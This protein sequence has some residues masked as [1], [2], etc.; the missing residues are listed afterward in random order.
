MTNLIKTT[1]QATDVTSNE[2]AIVDVNT[3]ASRYVRFGWAIVLFGVVGF[4]LWASFAPLDKAV[5]MSGTVSVASNR[6]A[7]QHQMGGTVDEILV[8]EGDVVKAGQAL[9]KMNS[10]SA[11]SN[12]EIARVQWFTALAA[13]ARLLAERDGAG[14]IKFPETLTQQ[15]NDLSVVNSMQLQSQ[16]FT[17]RRTS[18]QSEL[19]AIDE[20][21]AG[22]K[23]Q[24]R[25]LEDSM[26][27]KKQ[28]QIFLQEQLES[29]RE[30]SKDGY[31]ARNRLLDL[32]R[33]YA[34]LKGGISEELG[35]MRRVSRQVAELI[36]R[37]TQ[38][39]QDY[40]KEVRTQLSEVQKERESLQ[41][42]VNAMDFELSNVIVKAPVD[43]TIIGM[44]VFTQ[45][46]VVPSGFKLM[47]VVPKNDALIIDAMLAV[48]LI[49]KVQVGL[50]VEFLFAAFNTATTPKIPGVITQV[51]ADSTIDERSG[52]P[53][54]KV[55]AVVTPEG[56]KKLAQLQIRPGMPVELA[57]KTGE[58]TMMNYL[59]K[60]ILD[61][62]HT[63]L[64]ED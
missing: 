12:S 9:V 11:K 52:F 15:R 22:L 4:I 28:Q 29:M 41:S 2:V 17:A 1:G 25:G 51:S 18:I 21:I 48:N 57:V 24:L 50:P 23:V 6:K 53:H 38:R 19:G 43:G 49:D 39:Q 56:M 31:V 27:S 35:N 58:R 30:L 60:P 54:Y 7:V 36:L 63:A 64:G 46:G 37:K 13:E 34:Q 59:L 61:R 3:D 10:V 16:L 5:S 40:Q 33:T 44:N 45:G 42:R 47:E 8:K 62:A 20:N 14:S 26:I 55:K 32:E